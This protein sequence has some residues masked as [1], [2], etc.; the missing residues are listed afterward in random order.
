MYCFKKMVWKLRHGLALLL[1]MLAGTFAMAQSPQFKIDCN[2]SGRQL[3]EV[4]EPGYIPWTF[5]SGVK[6]TA[7]LGYRW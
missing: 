2:M 1:C 6:D 7:S 3:A 4:L 5:A